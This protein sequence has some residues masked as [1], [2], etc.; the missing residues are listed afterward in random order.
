M[1]DVAEL[2]DVSF[3]TVSRVVNSEAGV[4]P[5]LAE[6]VQAAVEQL[7]YA[8]DDRASGLRRSHQDLSTATIGVI[9]ADLANPFFTSVHSGLE[10]IASEK[11]T[12]ILT[13][14]SR[15]SRERQD[16]ILSAFTRRRVAGLAVVPAEA[17]EEPDDTPAF[18]AELERGTPLVFIDRDP[19]LPA[20]V[21]TSDHR[22][23]GVLAGQHLLDVG[24]R[25]IAF[26]GD[27]LRLF[28][29][30]QRLMGLADA[31]G[32]VGIEPVS[33]V[34]G[35]R[36]QE[37]AEQVTEEWMALSEDTRPTA[38][39]AAQN[40]LAGGVVKA[41]HRLG[42]QNEIALVGFDDIEMVDVIEPGMTTVPQ[43]TFELG[44]RAGQLLFDRIA[45]DTSSAKREVVPVSLVRRGTGEIPGPG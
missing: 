39:F 24:H 25:K 45:G 5:A 43:D 8:P 42:L 10:D 4:S 31:L 15:E 29:A 20:D 26:L 3:K 33:I 17:L 11:G 21:V 7:G 6:R 18:G 1:K 36:D 9:H 38:I 16:A 19:D 14:S 41:L 40:I 37:R 13:G 2:A 34:T 30:S 23:G 12:L 27:D 32:E 22:G 35:T 44:R 28:S